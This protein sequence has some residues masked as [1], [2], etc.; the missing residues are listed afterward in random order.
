LLH[1]FNPVVHYTIL[2][3]RRKRILRSEKKLIFGVLLSILVGNA[4]LLLFMSSLLSRQSAEQLAALRREKEIEIINELQ[5]RVETACS[6]INHIAA[7]VPDLDEA[8]RLSIAAMASLRFGENNYIWVHRLN[9]GNMKSAYMLVHPSIN[10][11]NQDLSGLIDLDEL[12]S[13]YHNGQIYKKNNPVVAKIR[14]T[15]IFK[16]FNI[17]SL[18]EGSGIVRYYWPKI[19]NGTPTTTGYCKLSFVK[20]FP[21]W[22]WVIGAGAYAD[23]IDKL[24]EINADEIQAANSL[25]FRNFLSLVAIL[26]LMVLLLVFFQIKKS[27]DIRQKA[28]E[29]LL[30]AKEKAEEANIAK[31][32][33]LANMS[34]EIRTPMNGILGLTA[35]VLD[36]S[37]SEKQRSF[38]LMVQKSA[39]RLMLII[40]DILDFSKIEAGKMEFLHEKFHLHRAVDEVITIMRIQADQ[41]SLQLVCQI[42]PAV[43]KL[44]VGDSNR[45]LQVIFNLIGNSIKFTHTGGIVLKISPLEQPAPEKITLQF[46]VIDTG[47]GVPPEKREIIFESFVQ[48]DGSHTRKYG[49]TGLGLTLS[50]QLVKMM[51]GNIGIESE[52]GRGS[53]F[54]FT[55]TFDTTN[56]SEDLP[57][58][59]EIAAIPDLS[60]EN[61]FAGMRALVVED[62]PFSRTLLQTL[63]QKKQISVSFAFDGDQAVM[64]VKEQQ[65]DIVLMDIEMPKLNGFEATVKIRDFEQQLDRHTPIIAITANAME[66]DRQRCLAAG[67]DDFISKPFD[68]N[69]LIQTIKR[70]LKNPE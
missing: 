63:L 60:E 42:D 64:A 20:Y 19:L 8:Q 51:G 62:E 52:P 49:G 36:T 7:T 40:N 43:P 39:D 66:L 38:L 17:I 22:H 53:T 61:E 14:P 33:F 6:I 29:A 56:G 54:W 57:E 5:G 48:A 13:I 9:P 21:E 27:Q 41:K 69:D 70:Q 44:L 32:A 25:L 4:V 30:Q 35:L 34:H 31:S 55:A 24:I 65:F 68:P 16:E 12:D 2:N 46:Q 23:H 26:S 37:L 10:L 28:E 58:H 15:E 1:E 18:N 59:H 11:I 67:M 45:L 50:S 47:I 3:W